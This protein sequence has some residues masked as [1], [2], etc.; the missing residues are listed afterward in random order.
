[1]VVTCAAPQCC[2][3]PDGIPTA[4]RENQTRWLNR[5]YS[6]CIGFGALVLLTA[7]LPMVL[8]EAPLSLPII[9]VIIGA[10]LFALPFD[11]SPL[12]VA[13]NLKIAERFTELVVIISLMGAALKIDRKIG[14]R[15]WLMTWRLLGLAMPITIFALAVL[16]QAMLGLG[17]ATA[18]LLAASLAP[19]DPVL[20]SDIQVG[21]PKSGEEDDTRF[22]LTSEAGLNDGLAFPFIM[23]AIALAQAGD[24]GEPWLLRWFG[25]E[26]IW[27]L[28]VG[29]AIGVFLGYLLGWL[30]F[31]LPNRAKL[32]RT[33]DGFVA[34]GIAVSVYGIAEA[35]HGYGFVSVFVAGLALRAS[36]RNHDY[37]Q[38]L[39]DFSEQLERLLMM[40]ALVVFGGLIWSGFFFDALSW[41]TAGYA[42]LA[43]FVVRPVVGWISL[44]GTAC[45]STERAVISFFG[46]R[47]LGTIYYLAYALQKGPFEKT[48]VIWSV[49]CL[50]ILISIV[51][52]W[53]HC[54]TSHAFDRSTLQSRHRVR[55]SE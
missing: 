6:Y 29:V 11:I 32:S 4:R 30:V 25:V 20:A 42:L 22:A 45:P 24:T 28:S 55:R 43:I 17:V 9:C 38:T 48:D 37:H 26:V 19:T 18:L 10:V 1:M 8:K 15:S 31:R 44:W 47:G 5:I 53:C 51:L 27:R 14:W 16:G 40:V 54:D 50:T 39:H 35:V 21:P 34:L 33:G 7:W 12:N 3:W 52:Q 36:E 23:C 49:A 41:S 46:I 13:A 2:F